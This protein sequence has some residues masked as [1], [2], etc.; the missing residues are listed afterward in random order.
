MVMLGTGSTPAYMGT[1]LREFGVRLA[2]ATASGLCVG[3]GWS[4]PWCGVFIVPRFR[5]ILLAGA[6]FAVGI[7]GP[8][9]KRDRSFW[10]RG[11]GLAALG[12]I[13]YLCAFMVGIR[14][15]A[16]WG[17]GDPGL[18]LACLVAAVV[19]L[20][21][22]RLIVPLAHPVRLTLAGSTAAIV[23]GYILSLPL[24]MYHW[25]AWTLWHV[26]MAVAIYGAESHASLPGRRR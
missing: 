25:V 5:C 26:V 15:I 23:G 22:A 17:L 16:G 4:L 8:Y 14:A 18:T 11:L 3:L 7:L 10:L 6:L 20:L 19:V 24:S 9:L 1:S 2:V 21:G 12:A 13:G